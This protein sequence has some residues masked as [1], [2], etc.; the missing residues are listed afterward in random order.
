MNLPHSLRL[1]APLCMLPAL[2]GAQNR[3]RGPF[4]PALTD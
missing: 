1:A 4:Q 3:G 2:A